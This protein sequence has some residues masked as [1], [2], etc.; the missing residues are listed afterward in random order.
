M[1]EDINTK[2]ERENIVNTDSK[3]KKPIILKILLVLVIALAIVGAF[4]GW[5][6]YSQEKEV[7]RNPQN[8]VIVKVGEEKLYQKDLTTELAYYP[9][10]DE[11][12][13]KQ[14]LSKMVEDSKL[15]QESKKEKTS[16][17]S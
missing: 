2:A 9:T 16:S 17:P 14:L 3:L 5:K 8:K 11:A 4:F 6:W 13:K 15:L 1:S 7:A 10:K 12:A